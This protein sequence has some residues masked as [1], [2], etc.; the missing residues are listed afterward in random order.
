[1]HQAP[2][3]SPTF[4]FRSA[5]RSSILIGRDGAGSR[6]AKLVKNIFVPHIFTNKYL[7]SVS[8]NFR[9]HT[10]FENFNLF[11]TVSNCEKSE[12]PVCRFRP[13][14]EALTKFSRFLFRFEGSFIAFFHVER[15]CCFLIF[16]QSNSFRSTHP[17]FKQNLRINLVAL[18]TNQPLHWRN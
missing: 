15:V 10:V 7:Q 11:G 14:G 4:P 13:I 5:D 1:M 16:S 3:A 8:T 6:C 17:D 9:A 18:T 2:F 12:Y